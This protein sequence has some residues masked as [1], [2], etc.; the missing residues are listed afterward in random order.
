[1]NIVEQM[2]EVYR[3]EV[4]PPNALSVQIT[5]CRRAF[6]A[7]VWAFYNFIGQNVPPGAGALTE[8]D[9]Q[10]IQSIED[11]CRQFNQDVLAGLK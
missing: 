11:E 9:I 3:N 7:G 2:W 10:V 6:Y 8:Y 1:M 4:I 5:E